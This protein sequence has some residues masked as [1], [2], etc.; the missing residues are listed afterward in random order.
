MLW[1]NFLWFRCTFCPTQRRW[2]RVAGSVVLCETESLRWV[3]RRNVL[4]TMRIG[5]VSNLNEPVSVY[6]MCGHIGEM[7][8]TNNEDWCLLSRCVPVMCWYVHWCP[9]VLCFNGVLLW[10]G[11][12][13]DWEVSAV[14][15][16]W[17]F[18]GV[19]GFV[20][21]CIHTCFENVKQLN[22][23]LGWTYVFVNILVN[24]AYVY[25]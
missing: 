9:V 19:C 23:P 1:G 13:G 17:N 10:F 7:L 12:C 25:G 11:F 16:F 6:R 14:M 8:W 5:V 15:P 22:L 3:Q 21:F 20:S 4:P 2:D 24:I 18:F